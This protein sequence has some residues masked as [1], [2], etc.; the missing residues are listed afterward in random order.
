LTMY[1]TDV[2]PTAEDLAQHVTEAVHPA[3]K[4]LCAQLETVEWSKPAI[5]VVIKETLTKHG[6]KMPQ[7]AHAVRVLV[8]G[9][10]QTP[11]LDTV[12][13]LFTRETVLARLQNH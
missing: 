11:S 9:R 2:A 7:L 12:L 8:C 1:F 4:S 6:L 10:G 13:E 5:A 3:L